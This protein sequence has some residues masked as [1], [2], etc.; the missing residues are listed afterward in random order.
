MY[1][2]Q[3]RDHWFGQANPAPT[4]DDL[5][6]F[7]PLFCL[8]VIKRILKESS[9]EYF[10]FTM[11]VFTSIICFN[12]SPAKSFY[13]GTDWIL[14]LNRLKETTDAN[15]LIIRTDGLKSADAPIYFEKNVNP[16]ECVVSNL[17]DIQIKQEYRFEANLQ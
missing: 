2:S 17:S 10:L 13:D 16:A 9:K 5:I 8:A 15:P 4:V 1:Y 3:G 12:G 6:D 7:T 11:P 14:S